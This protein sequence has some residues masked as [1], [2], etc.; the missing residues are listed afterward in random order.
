VRIATGAIER[1][2]TAGKKPTPD[3]IRSEIEKTTGYVG[4]NGVVNM[5]PK[6]HMGLDNSAFII[7][8]VKDG[9]WQLAE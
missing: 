9:D 5:T 3:A 6:D 8:V 1:V 7:A 4:L 2:I